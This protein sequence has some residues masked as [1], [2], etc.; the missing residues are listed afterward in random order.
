MPAEDASSAPSTGL[1]KVV[2]GSTDKPITF[3]NPGKLEG[4]V[5][6]RKVVL[7]MS[8]VQFKYDTA[9]KPILTDAS[10]TLCLS[11]RVALIGA[12]GAGNTP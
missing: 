4:I 5:G 6:R 12:N 11:S 10:G 1:D 2:S 7:R 8:N 9:E 3:A